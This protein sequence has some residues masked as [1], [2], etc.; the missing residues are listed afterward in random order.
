ME[1]HVYV[2]SLVAPVKVELE[3]RGVPWGWL[4]DI[5]P[6][7]GTQNCSVLADAINALTLDVFQHPKNQSL[8][9]NTVSDLSDLKKTWRDCCANGCVYDVY[10]TT[11]LRPS[12]QRRGWGKAEGF[13]YDK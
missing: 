9:V 13:S 7:D 1:L 4:L 8:G 2:F 5:L 10:E 11:E 3:L 12:L 6:E